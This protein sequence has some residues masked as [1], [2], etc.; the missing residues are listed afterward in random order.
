MAHA[1]RSECGVNQSAAQALE[2]HQVPEPV[3]DRPGGQLPAG[4][5]AEQ[6]SRAGEPAMNVIE[7]PAQLQVQ[8]VQHRHPPRPGPR[9]ARR[10]AEPHMQLPERAAAEVNV[11]DVQQDGLLAADPGVIEVR[12]RA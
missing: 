9:R 10:L 2:F 6:R 8:A 12:N 3:A 1:L 7:E 5:V 4:L 11:R